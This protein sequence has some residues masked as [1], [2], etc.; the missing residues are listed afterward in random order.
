MYPQPQLAHLV[1]RKHALRAQ[2][3]RRRARCAEA[4]AVVTRPLRWLDQL[5]A[6]WRDFAPF[7]LAVGL[8]LGLLARHGRTPP[9]KP[10]SSIACWGP[11]AFSLVRK[12]LGQC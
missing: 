6:L 2:I 8:P 5:I 1:S 4:A 12:L 9:Q 7:A 3:H 10:R 11:L